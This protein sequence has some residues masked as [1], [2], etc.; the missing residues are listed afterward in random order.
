MAIHPPINHHRKAAAAHAVA[1]EQPLAT[2][3][4]AVAAELA[5]SVVLQALPGTT[6]HLSGVY[7]SSGGAL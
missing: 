2:T 6:S 5:I 4:M 7:G 3:A 1:A